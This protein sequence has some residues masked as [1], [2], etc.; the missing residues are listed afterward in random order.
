VTAATNSALR[1]SACLKADLDRPEWKHKTA[2]EGLDHALTLLRSQMGPLIDGEDCQRYRDVLRCARA[3][4]NAVSRL[5]A[6]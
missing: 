6:K 4:A 3:L 2:R 1:L 5:H